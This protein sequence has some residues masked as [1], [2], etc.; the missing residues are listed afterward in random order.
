MKK[1]LNGLNSHKNKEPIAN[2]CNLT[3]QRPDFFP[4]CLGTHAYMAEKAEL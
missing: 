3:S 2:H 4:A 1:G